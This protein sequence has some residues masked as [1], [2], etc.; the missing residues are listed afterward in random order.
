[1]RNFGN[2]HTPYKNYGPPRHFRF[3]QKGDFETIPLY[4]AP[5][6][7]SQF[8]PAPRNV[9]VLSTPP[10]RSASDKAKGALAIGGIG[11]AIV[12]ALTIMPLVVWPFVIKSFRPDLPYGRRVGIGLGISIGL[13]AVGGVARAAFGEKES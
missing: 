8:M 7:G 10:E 11:L 4:T 3:S 1:M 5:S 12:G 13:A 9:P 6:Y 2:A